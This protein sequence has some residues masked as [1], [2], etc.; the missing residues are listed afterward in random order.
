[1]CNNVVFEWHGSVGKWPHGKSW[2]LI[3]VILVSY[4]AGSDIK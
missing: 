4:A 1:M 3:I 2:I